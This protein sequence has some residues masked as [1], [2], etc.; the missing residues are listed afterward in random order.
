MNKEQEDA[1]KE[2]N[3]ILLIAGAGSGKTTTIIQKVNYLIEKHIY[4]EKDILVIS[5]TNESVNDLKKK[6]K[7]N[8][9]ILTFHKLAIK[10]IND[11][12]FSLC[13]NY[14]LDYIIDEYFN[15]LNKF[16][17]I[18]YRLLMENNYSNLKETIKTFI[19]LYKCNYENII[20]LY[21]LF[22]NSHFLQKDYYKVIMDIYYI[23]S[24][25]LEASGKLDYN[26]LIIKATNLL[27]NKERKENYKITI[28]DEFQDTSL[29]RLKLILALKTK[30][31]LVGDDY[32]SIYRFSGCDLN[33]FLN[34][35]NYLKDIQIKKLKNN[36]RN[37]SE[38]IKIAN[39]FIIKNPQQIKKEI[40]CFKT[41]NKPIKIIKYVD[42]KK[43]INK[44]LNI[45]DDNYIILGRNNKDKIDFGV[46]DGFLT[47][48]KSKGLEFNDVIV[49]NLENDNNSLPSKRENNN[50]INKI[51]ICD[52][53]LY[54]EERRLFYVALTRA[55]NNVYLVIPYNNYSI[56]VKELEKD[57]KK[58][59]DYLF[60]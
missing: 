38:L 5:F 53:Y 11:N 37:S 32:Q 54:E 14:F 25:E 60:L 41:I 21:D 45:I 50:I 46:Q 13:D 24:K 19:N 12:N 31:F 39:N 55:K 15:N 8:I 30:Y 51:A 7:Y 10:I 4:Q 40:V 44:L 3:N 9:D 56:F 28:V 43:V 57:Y 35:K 18:K 33:V 1:V 2:N 29:I 6:I 27:I 36:Y 17:L 47:I 42:K 20:K 59:I 26:D 48:H 49:I 58:Y 22:N 34:I 52:N 16:S 23:Y